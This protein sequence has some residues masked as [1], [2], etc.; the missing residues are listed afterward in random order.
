MSPAKTAQS[1]AVRLLEKAHSR[2]GNRCTEPTGLSP[3]F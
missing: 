1:Q 2:A 3:L